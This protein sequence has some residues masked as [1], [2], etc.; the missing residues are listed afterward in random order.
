MSL[1]RPYDGIAIACPVTVPYQRFSERPALWF[2]GTAL[3]LLIERSG[4]AKRDIDGLSASSFSLAPDG[5]VSFAEQ[6]RLT[7]RYI[8]WQPTGGASGVLAIRRAA[9]AIQCGDADVIACIAGDTSRP[10][11][12]A[13]LIDN[14]SSFS[15]AAIVP[16]GATG[17]NGPFAL[18]TD[19]YLRA[20]GL[21]VDA[22]APLVLSARSNASR[23]ANALLKD[24]PLDLEAYR[25]ARPIV[26]PVRLNDCVMPCA[27][28]EGCLVMT[29]DRA[30]AL[31]LPYA[32][33]RGAIERHGLGLDDPVARHGGWVMDRD[34]LWQQAG[35]GPADIDCVQTYDDYPVIS[36]MQLIDLGFCASGDAAPFLAQTDFTVAGTLPHNTGG[37][38]LGCGQAGAAGGY[39]GLTEALGQVIGTPPGAQVQ[40]ARLALVS[41]FGMV[42]YDRGVCSAAAILE[43]HQA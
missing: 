32:T 1:P 22:L 37:G 43:G 3:R 17:P 28:G 5:V 19:H 14:F 2:L 40:D 6:V 34:S 27:G 13:D 15:S 36:L 24:R 26:E 16:L 8:D 35:L 12:F 9:R 18:I 29:V 11:S 42:T 31:G 4:L 41:G 23:N 33:L 10:G 30:R 39:L 20:H 38:Q 21:G 25:T 7:P